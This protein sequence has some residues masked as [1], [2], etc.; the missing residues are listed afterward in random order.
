MLVPGTRDVG[1]VVWDKASYLLCGRQG[2]VHSRCCLWC[3]GH[4][5]LGIRPGCN[6]HPHQH[7]LIFTVSLAEVLQHTH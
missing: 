6:R 1:Q 7:P 4:L 2:V 3:P 5:R